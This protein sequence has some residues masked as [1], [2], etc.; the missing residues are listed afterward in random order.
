MNSISGVMSCETEWHHAAGSLAP[1][2][3]YKWT[4]DEDTRKSTMTRQQSM[5]LWPHPENNP[6]LG[7]HAL[8]S[9]FS[10]IYWNYTVIQ[11]NRLRVWS[12]FPAFKGRFQTVQL[13]LIRDFTHYIHITDDYWAEISSCHPDKMDN[14]KVFDHCCSVLTFIKCFWGHTDV[15]RYFHAI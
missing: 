5:W 15:H 6:G 11:D 13:V 12:S 14:S 4:P 2:A 8:W 9:I 10:A 3:D 1:L 7:L